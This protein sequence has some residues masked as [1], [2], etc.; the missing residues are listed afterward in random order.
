MAN[1][2]TNTNKELVNLR[3]NEYNTQDT[4][5]SL[6]YT[7]FISKEVVPEIIK[8]NEIDSSSCTNDSSIA[9]AYILNLNTIRGGSKMIK[10][11]GC[12]CSGM[13]GGCFTCKKGV[14]NITL[15]YKTVHVIIPELYSKYNKE[16]S[17]KGISKKAKKAKKVKKYKTV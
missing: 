9:T 17:M 8:E 16:A 10:G 13:S 3:L 6:N 1:A 15:I 11:G 7:K 4:Q 12:G 14:K 5:D 2:I